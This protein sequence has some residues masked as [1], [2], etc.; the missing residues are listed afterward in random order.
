[1]TDKTNCLHCNNSLATEFSNI[2]GTCD[3]GICRHCAE[4]F[5]IEV[6]KLADVAYQTCEYCTSD[7]DKYCKECKDHINNIL[8][9]IQKSNNNKYDLKLYKVDSIDKITHKMVNEQVF[10]KD[11]RCECNPNCKCHSTARETMKTKWNLNNLILYEIYDEAIDY[12]VVRCHKCM[13]D[14]GVVIGERQAF[15]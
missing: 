6:N 12:C 4:E 1:M 13:I 9:R 8:E 3:N 10:G 2:C 11:A 15:F 5:R 14:T 7:Y